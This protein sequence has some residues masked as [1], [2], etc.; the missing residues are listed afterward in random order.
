[1]TNR[2]VVDRTG[3]RPLYLQVSD[4]IGHQI[5]GRTLLPGEALPSEAELQRVFGVARSVV[6]QALGRLVDSGEVQ[7][8]QGR[9]SIVEPSPEWRRRV[10]QAGGF[11]EQLATRG[12]TLTTRLLSFEAGQAPDQAESELGTARTWRLE[13]VRSVDG[14]PVAFVRNWV[15]RD[16][17][18]ELTAAQLTAGSL[19]DLMRASGMPPAGGRRHVQA[20]PADEF[21]AS[22]LEVAIGDPLLLLEG[23]T[24]NTAGRGLEWFSVWHRGHTVFDVDTAVHPWPEDER[25]VDAD[26]SRLHETAQRLSREV[27]QLNTHLR[28]L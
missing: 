8:T 18:P 16:V 26:L 19:H 13:R 3:D 12:Q 6:R 10:Q 17:L 11:T 28:N 23:T 14:V 15:P 20:V 25:A 1:M 7:R 22:A 9:I 5:S 2:L 4:A 24:R 21:L 27:E